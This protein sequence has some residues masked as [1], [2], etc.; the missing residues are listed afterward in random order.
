MY[1]PYIA[2]YIISIFQRI[3]TFP[4]L[5]SNNT[6]SIANISTTTKIYGK[7]NG[8]LVIFVVYG[9]RKLTD[10]T[11]WAWLRNCILLIVS[12]ILNCYDY[13]AINIDLST[14]NYSEEIYVELT[15]F[16]S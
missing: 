7:L 3:A 16:N 11:C 12:I 9:V 2:S 4:T 6:I 13:I 8:R 10:K 1:L 14:C 5:I 15:R